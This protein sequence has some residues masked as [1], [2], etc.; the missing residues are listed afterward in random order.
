MPEQSATYISRTSGLKFKDYAG[1]AMVDLAGCLVFSLVTT[2]LQKF[3]TD[4]FHLSPLFIMIMFII[5]RVWDGINDP[6]MGRI[7]DTVK[8]GK[9]G[10]YRPWILY[11]SLPLTLSAVLMFVKFPGI[12]EEGHYTATCVYATCTYIFFGMAYTV[13]QIPY[14]SLASVVTTDAGERSK[15]SVFR[16]IGAA[17]GSIPV[18]LIASF[19][20]EKRLDAAG[21][22]VMGE[23][24]KAITDMQYGPVIRGVVIM[25]LCSLILLIISFTMNRERVKTKPNPVSSG[26]AR[27]VIALLFKNRAFVAVTMASMLLLAGQMFTQSFYTYLF[28]DYFHANWMNLATQACTY[29]PMIIFMF[30]LPKLA[31][32]RGK[33]EITSVGMTVAAVANLLLFFLR[34][35]DPSVLMWIFLAMNFVSGCGLT[36]L[37]MQLWAMVTDAI[38]DIE[39]STGSRDDGTAYSVFNL[40]RKVGQVIAAICVNGALLGMDYKYE[41]G[42]VQTLENLKV[43]YDLGTLIPAVMFGIMA[44][45]LFAWY[46]LSREKVAELQVKKEHKL[47]ESYES[48]E[49]DI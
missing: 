38:D 9:Y 13:L 46:P 47:K 15:L 17:L 27:K 10:R 19:A 31:G 35:L 42:A 32:T 26:S 41:K 33:K 11:A 21:N 4:I 2:L 3:Y 28:D 45:I 40:F 36:T 24:G 5:A 30:F 39:V 37:V 6:I 1:Y 44:V 25:A 16:S 18:L 49:I 34:G 7:A 12:G 48:K 29:S 23:N 43:M 8:P 14:G 20:Y 22:V